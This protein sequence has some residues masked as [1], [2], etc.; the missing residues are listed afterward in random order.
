MKRF[1]IRQWKDVNLLMQNMKP[2]IFHDEGKNIVKSIV[3]CS[4]LLTM[5]AMKK[6][7]PH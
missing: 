1:K 6:V 4:L 2:H 7:G 3:G 5:G